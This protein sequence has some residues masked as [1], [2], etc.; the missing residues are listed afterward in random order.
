MRKR[1]PY[2]HLLSIFPFLP[3]L[4]SIGLRGKTKQQSS[5]ISQFGIVFFQGR[6]GK[7]VIYVWASG[8]GGGAGD[9][10]DCDGYTNSIHT[11]SIS[12]G[13]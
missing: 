4:K 1:N 2:F 5:L 8:N 6:N 3:Q 7:G 10:C 13:Q 9:N 12:S 11:L